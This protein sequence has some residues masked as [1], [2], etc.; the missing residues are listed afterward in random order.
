MIAFLLFF[1]VGLR[2]SYRKSA[3]NEAIS[4]FCGEILLL[5]TTRVKKSTPYR[6]RTRANTAGLQ[7]TLR[8]TTAPTEVPGDVF[9]AL[10]EENEE[11]A[12][13]ATASGVVCEVNRSARKLL[14]LG[15]N[16]KAL[17][18][19][20]LFPSWKVSAKKLTRAST[21]EAEPD[22]VHELVR[23]NG[24]T[25][26][27]AVRV[28]EVGN[29]LFLLQLSEAG[30]ATHP[31]DILPELLPYRY[32]EGKGSY[33]A[34]VQHAPY[35]I[36]VIRGSQCVYAN[37]T[38][39]RILGYRSA[40]GLVGKKFR[41][42]VVDQSQRPVELLMDRKLKGENIPSKFETK[43]VRVDGS[44][45]EAEFSLTLIVHEGRPAV[46][47]SITDIT[48]RKLLERR[49]IDSE[50]LFRNVVNS[51]VDSLV[52]T[53][54][55]GK[56]LDVNEEFEKLTGFTRQEVFG[57]EIPYPWVAEEDLRSYIGWLQMLREH[58]YLKDYGVTWTR[59]DGRRI[60]V[61]LSTTLLRNT[62][63]APMLMVNIARDITER[64]A[65]QEE[66][67]RQLHR[68]QVLYEF[69]R[70]LSEAWSLQEIGSKTFQ[71]I[72][73]VM[74]V[75]A[76]FMDLYD[77]DRQVLLPF[78]LVDESV[79][80]GTD[81]PAREIPLESA[82]AC[83][84]VI[85]QKRSFLELRPSS[86]QQPQYLPIGNKDRASSSLMYV[87]L[88]SKNHI[89]GILSVQSYEP[90]AYSEGHL[91]LVENMASVAAIALEK[92]V[93]Y[94]ETILKSQQLEERNKELDDFTYVVSHDLK[95]PLISVEGYAKIIRHDY[96]H[97]LDENG[98]Q[99]IRSI[100][101]ACLH[102]KKLIEEL[103]ELSR[104]SKLV[105]R[106]SEVD[107]NRLIN[108]VIQELRFTI[109]ERKAQMVIAEDLPRIVAVEPHVKIVFR[110]LFANALK[111]AGNKPPRIEVG[112]QRNNENPVFFVKDYGIGIEKEYHDKVF[113]IFQRLHHRED[114]EGTGAG[115]TIVKKIIDA[116][117]GTIWIDS[118]PNKG[119]TFFFTFGG[120]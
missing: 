12:L 81:R 92:V 93:L 100:L 79:Q 15:R 41:T 87:P 25:V 74:P 2:Y 4:C 13:L 107:L 67:A 6:S 96:G 99:F 52:I 106:R 116:H 51:M 22:A 94:Q 30:E 31:S 10:F 86:V 76:F 90:N 88:F 23:R 118:E 66:V 102:M 8:R 33:Y 89:K 119:T 49:L 82:P 98:Q 45:V 62:S 84:R 108:E 113:M 37:S 54:L 114:Y 32:G 40:D 24:S 103:L 55:R 78:F 20:D 64:H 109:R 63:G 112:V 95:E 26:R 110:N 28:R 60:A 83:Q 3:Y 47:A 14:K 5:S 46:S 59:K 53:D 65:Q 73:R 29:K 36:A 9:R 58:G 34:L 120:R 75:D 16:A 48:D 56:V 42:I 18:L 21:E 27:V 72:K 91:A 44:E 71:L 50:R 69:S 105:E 43:L 38:L 7:T 111:F 11:P 117:R 101:D 104:V 57:K 39:L 115:M 80:E 70:A 85:E 19:R 77:E 1:G 68:V 17:H 97:L 61:S 35:G